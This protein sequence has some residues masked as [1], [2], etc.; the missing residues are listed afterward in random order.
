MI[1]KFIKNLYPYMVDNI[2]HI[3]D[4]KAKVIIEK[5]FAIEYVEEEKPKKKRG[6]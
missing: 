1:V 6:E 4:K 3:E 5:K 2:V